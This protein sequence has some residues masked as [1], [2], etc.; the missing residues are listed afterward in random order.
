VFIEE[1]NARVI[2]R[3]PESS[4]NTGFQFSYID[5]PEV[6]RNE[7]QVT[8]GFCVVTSPTTIAFHASSLMEG[9]CQQDHAGEEMLLHAIGFKPGR[10]KDLVTFPVVTVIKQR[11]SITQRVSPLAH[12]T[13]ILEAI[14]HVAL[15]LL[16]KTDDASQARCIKKAL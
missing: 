9:G 8:Q 6:V 3:I 13:S 15:E 4:M 12:I 10:F 14:S 16:S 11:N 2:H 1:W 7:C 5:S